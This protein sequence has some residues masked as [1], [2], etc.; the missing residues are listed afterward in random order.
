MAKINVRK[1]PICGRY[2]MSQTPAKLGS[3]YC[4]D[5]SALVL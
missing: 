2:D 1:Q 3:R 4:V 5:M